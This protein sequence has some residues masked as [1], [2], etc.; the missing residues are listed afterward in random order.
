MSSFQIFSVK[1]LYIDSDPE[2][3]QRVEK[4]VKND[5]SEFDLF[6]QA[7]LYTTMKPQETEAT[8]AKPFV[9]DFLQQV[10]DLPI[11]RR[12][13]KI[14]SKELEVAGNED[15]EV[16]IPVIG[17][18]LN[19]IIEEISNI[20]KDIQSEEGILEQ[21]DGKIID[22]STESVDEKSNFLG[23]T[24]PSTTVKA[25]SAQD[26]S[27]VSLEDRE[28]VTSGSNPLFTE[29]L[30]E[31]VSTKSAET[32]TTKPNLF[33]KLREDLKMKVLLLKNRNKIRLDKENVQTSTTTTLP[34]TTAIR[35][36]V[37]KN[38][39]FPL[40]SF[41]ANKIKVLF[42]T[43]PNSSDRLNSKDSCQPKET[44]ISEDNNSNNDVEEPIDS[45]ESEFQQKM[46]KSRSAKRAAPN[47]NPTPAPL[48]PLP[49]LFPTMNRPSFMED[50][51]VE[52]AEKFNE[53]IHR[54]MQFVGIMAQ[55]DSFITSR[56]RNTIK[57]LNQL[58]GPDDSPMPYN[59][60]SIKNSESFT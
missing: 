8:S 2:V 44:L 45:V 30:N 36:I 24:V 27:V 41:K 47:G 16:N 18:Q 55:I 14:E 38:Q 46:L 50:N 53:G 25:N 22:Y 11:F 34:T 12:Y 29:K 1:S 31:E 13:K 20:E 3:L 7:A 59:L 4:D 5:V 28:S 49:T 23:S 52:R 48:I 37:I 19:K 42:N 33:G 32:T 26:Q 51:S 17:A 10:E 35:E 21:F 6:P 54:L 56:A 43:H 40:N 39:N 60:K 58:Y 9:L 57:K 15:L